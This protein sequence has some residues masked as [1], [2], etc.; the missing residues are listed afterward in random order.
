[1]DVTL[2]TTTGARADVWREADPFDAPRADD[3][4]K[5]QTCLSVDLFGVIA[6]LADR[7]LDNTTQAAEALALAAHAQRRLRST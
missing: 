6:E 3:V 7:H 2:V 4:T 5:P 1:M